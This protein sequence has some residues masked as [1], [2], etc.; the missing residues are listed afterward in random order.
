MGNTV[1]NF[2]L[3]ELRADKNL[4]ATVQYLSDGVLQQ[5]KQVCKSCQRPIGE[6]KRQSNE[7]FYNRG[8]KGVK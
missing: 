4:V 1:C 2:T 7:K 5:E 6:H 8:I 3:D